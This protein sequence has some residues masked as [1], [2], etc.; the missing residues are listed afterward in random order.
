[1]DKK[2]FKILCTKNLLIRTHVNIV[3]YVENNLCVSIDRVSSDYI[4]VV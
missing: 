4:Q 1:M 3:V 2:I